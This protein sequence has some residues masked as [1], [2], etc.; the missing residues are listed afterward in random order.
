MARILISYFS[1]YGEAM[2][3]AIIKELKENGNDI[4]RFNI[5]NPKV[6]ITRWGGESWIVDS[7]LLKQICDFNPECILNFNNCLPQNCYDI[8]EKKCL[9]CLIDASI[10]I[11]TNTIAPYNISIKLLLFLYFFFFSFFF[12]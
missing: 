7:S 8:I 2:Y 9:I 10:S 6:S 4:F 1:D 3:D 12:R 5:N 11:T